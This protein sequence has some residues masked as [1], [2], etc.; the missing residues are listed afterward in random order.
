M[1]T[2]FCVLFCTASEE[3]SAKIAK[4]LIEERLVACV[5]ITGVNSYYR[6]EGEFCE[7]NE[8]LLIMKTEKRMVNRV[9]KRIKDV[10]SY[11]VPEIIA[12]P[13]VA[14]YDKY[15]AWIEASVD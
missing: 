2:E 6:W 9:I 14:G 7:D 10:H 11:E 3:E 15:L 4:V 8:A 5:N 13:I 1:S 12:L